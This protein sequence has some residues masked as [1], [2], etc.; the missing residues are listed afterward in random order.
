MKPKNYDKYVTRMA[1][2]G[3]RSIIMFGK[4]WPPYRPA[5]TA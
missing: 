4:R 2:A 1:N 3:H 5:T